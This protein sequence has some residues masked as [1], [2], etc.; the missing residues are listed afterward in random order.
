MKKLLF[1]IILILFA[2][3]CFAA[4]YYVADEAAGSD[5][6]SSC[7]NAD[8]L[9]DLTWGT[10][11]MVKAGDTLHLCG[12]ITSTLA[13][14]ASGTAGSPITIKFEDDAKL[15]STVWVNSYYGSTSAIDTNNYDYLI[16]DGGTN[17]VIENTANGTELANQTASNAIMA[18]GSN[19]IE[20]KNLTIQNLYVRTSTTDVVM[21]SFGGSSSTQAIKIGGSNSN[22]I[23][24]HDC[25]INNAVAGIYYAGSA[26][27]DNIRIYNNTFSD[28]DHNIAMG[29]SGGTISNLYIFGNSFA[30]YDTWDDTTGTNK[31][32][33]N[34]AHIFTVGSAT[35]N[36]VFVYGNTF[37]GSTGLY[38]TAHFYFENGSGGTFN[39]LQIYNNLLLQPSNTNGIWQIAVGSTSGTAVTNSFIANNTIFGT[40]TS[41]HYGIVV[42]GGTG[43][44]IVVKNNAVIGCRSA[45]YEYNATTNVT[46]DNNLYSGNANIGITNGG[47]T[48][49]TLAAWRTHLGG[50]ETGD[51]YNASS[52]AHGLNTSG[53]PQ[54]GAGVL[55]IGEDLSAS[56][57][58]DY[59]GNVRP[60]GAGTWD[61]GAYES[62]ASADTTPPTITS[63]TV[64]TD[65]DT[66][67]LVFDEVVTV[68][69]STG[70]TLNM[71][72]GAAGLTYS[73]GSGTNTL[74][75][76]ITVR[77]IDTAETGTLDYAT[78]AN[79]I[80]DAAGN[81]LAS[82]GESDIA[83]T[84]NSEYS[85]SA[86]T[87]IVTLQASG[88]CTVSPLSNK[89]IVSGE[90][91]SYTCA[92]N[93]N[94]GCAAW[95][96]T[97]TGTGTTSFTSSAIKSDCTVIQGCY[98][99]A[100]D[101]AIGS[102]GA[103]VT[104]GSGAVGTLY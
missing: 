35:Y 53:V 44:A 55:N 74:V 18:T 27:M 15:S 1:T 96:G 17:G 58:T 68:N 71:S 42:S 9:A 6:G 66:L 41:G 57:T 73:S 86:T 43:N 7:A 50:T 46:Y 87:Y 30:D 5:N 12:T 67:T 95:T 4:D 51:D 25:T 88:D 16:I 10:G 28:I 91:A 92:A 89:V 34:A 84:N 98:K 39:N 78:V 99:I 47:G 72:G 61:I 56:F 62:G 8:A 76:N 31:Y 101:V 23:L 26:T 82:T 63:A 104:L 20:I 79:G 77:N 100:P 52:A 90:T 69:T 2:V 33:H 97:C 102:G 80:E 29:A 54:A 13:I 32:H 3:P 49:S 81:D 24:I 60:T 22:N 19:D 64:G 93:G 48:Y 94:S 83:V 65:G 70:F 37:S 103:A 14:G 59:A 11:N 75:Y 36:G 85:P 45:I 21:Q 40:N 38:S